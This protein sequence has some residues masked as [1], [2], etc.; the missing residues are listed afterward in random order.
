M[1]KMAWEILG[2]KRG[3]DPDGRA[4]RMGWGSRLALTVP[5]GAG[6]HWYHQR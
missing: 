2:E 6:I 3:A 5:M 1:G 4:G